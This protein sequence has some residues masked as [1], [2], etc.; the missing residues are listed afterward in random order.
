MR[1]KVAQPKTRNFCIIAHIDHGKS[2]LADRLLEITGTVPKD[3]LREQFLDQMELERERGITIKSHPITMY[4]QGYTLNLIDTPGHVDFTYEVSRALAAADG[5]L[6][7]VDA[8]QGIQAQTLANYNLA[9]DIGLELIPV[10]NKIDL[11]GAEP[12]RVAKEIED[13]L[14]LDEPIMV[15]AKYGT[16]VELLLDAIIKRIPPPKGDPD[17]PLRALVFDAF[18]DNYRGVVVFVRV[19]D[20]KV[21]KGQMVRFMATGTVHQVEEVGIFRP[22]LS[23]KDELV[24]GDVGYIIAGIKRIEVASVGDTLTDA[25]AVSVEPLPGYREPKPMVFCSFYPTNSEDYEKLLAAVAK[26]KLNDAALQW[27]KES[28]S[29]LGYGIRCGFLG[30]LHMQVVQERLEREFNLDLIATTPNVRYK[31]KLAD[32]RELEIDN[33]AHWPED[34]KILKV[35]E[36]VVKANIITPAEYLGP[37]IKLIQN[38]RGQVMHTETLGNSVRLETIIPLTEL[39]VDFYDMLKSASRGYASLDYDFYGYQESDM[40]KLNILIHGQVVDSLSLIVHRDKAY[41]IGRQV[42]SKLKELIPRQLFEFKIQ[43]AIGRKVIA[44]VTVKPLRR[45]VLAKCYGGDVTRKKKLLE[46]QKRGKKRMKAIGK[47]NVPQEAF[48]A[49]LKVSSSSEEQR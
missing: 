24:A 6:L 49:L 29:S 19:V 36:P 18:Y 27:T 34:T 9:L 16:N 4:W 42:V 17:A 25:D 5:A 22:H 3:R 12:E 48:W 8:T 13:V 2:T 43:A 20:G 31:L 26:L 44:S 21:S 28:S 32:G 33:P 10:I 39:I 1:Q 46:K 35:Y 23:P 7:V 45:D 38:R 41:W 47:V 11:Q 15:S 40:I 37:I 14:L 30:L